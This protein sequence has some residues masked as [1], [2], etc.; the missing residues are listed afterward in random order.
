M[1]KALLLMAAFIAMCSCAPAQEVPTAQDVPITQWR[2]GLIE[3]NEDWEEHDGDNLAWA[4]PEFDSRTW[5]IVD[6]EDMG[7]AKIGWSW[8]RKH[9]LVGPDYPNVRL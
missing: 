6:L 8:Y 9:V 7:P 3:L 1:R 5:K 4:T 2:S